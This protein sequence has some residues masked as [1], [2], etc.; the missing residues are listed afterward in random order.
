LTPQ[1][2]HPYNDAHSTRQKESK[3]RKEMGAGMSR[4]AV[5]TINIDGAARGNPGPAAFAY[6]I[7]RDGQLLSEE[8]GCLGKATNNLA[9]YTALVRALERAAEL[10]GE[11][12]LIRSDS[13]LLVKQMNGLYRVKNPQ[14]KV[15]YDQANRL[16]EQFASVSIV[17]VPRAENSHADRLCNEALD[18]LR[19]PAQSAI[20][21]EQKPSNGHDASPEDVVREKALACVR[22]A[23]SAWMRGD[24]A[25]PTPEKVWEQIRDI[26]EKGLP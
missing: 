16:R 4:S 12:L 9:E 8:A 11:R 14:L 26:I 6:V 10:G 17:H 15:L 2:L 21:R 24:P 7:A 3:I 18:G 19:E 20:S 5:L 1:S 23:A 22:A 13:E 25:A